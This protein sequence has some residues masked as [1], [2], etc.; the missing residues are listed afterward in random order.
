MPRSTDEIDAEKA[1]KSRPDLL[2]G[3]AALAKGD[4]QAFGLA[5]HGPCTWRDKGTEQAD[6]RT[7]LASASRHAAF[8]FDDPWS[9]DEQTGLLH[10]AHLGAQI[11]IALD[12]LRASDPVRFDAIRATLPAALERMRQASLAETLT[13]GP[14]AFAAGQIEGE[15]PRVAPGFA[16]PASGRCPCPTPS[17]C[18]AAQRCVKGLR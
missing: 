15:M 9:I 1:A 4:V 5:K 7:H 16:I 14:S 18:H 11:D 3:T 12:C 10:L 17:Q 2:P 13:G 6:P 8:V